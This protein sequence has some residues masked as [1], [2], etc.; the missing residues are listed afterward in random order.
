MYVRV[1][2]RTSNLLPNQQQSKRRQ[3]PGFVCSIAMN[4]SF[5]TSEYLIGRSSHTHAMLD[6]RPPPLSPTRSTASFAEI[7]INETQALT[8]KPDKPA[9]VGVPPTGDDRHFFF[10][11]TAR[12][13]K[14]SEITTKRHPLPPSPSPSRSGKIPA[15]PLTSEVPS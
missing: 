10:A 7:R 11:P 13:T 8:K 2:S 3:P 15:P 12:R 14:I 6:P 1:A 5:N 9:S 4:N